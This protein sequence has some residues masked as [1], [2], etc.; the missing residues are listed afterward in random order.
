[1]SPDPNAVIPKVV[2]GVLNVL[3]AASKHASVK[4]FVLTSSSSAALIPSPNE[5]IVVDESM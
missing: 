1:M 3:E 4:R 2:A 5:K